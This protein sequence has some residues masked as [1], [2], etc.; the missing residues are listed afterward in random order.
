M[1]SIIPAAEQRCMRHSPWSTIG[2]DGIIVNLSRFKGVAVDVGNGVATVTGGTPMKELQGALHPHKRFAAVG[3]GNTVGVILYYLGGGISIYTPLIGFGAE[4]IVSARLVAAAGELVEAT[5]QATPSSSG[6]L[7]S[8][9]Q[10]LG[11]VTALMIRTHPYALTGGSACAALM[12]SSRTRPTPALHDRAGSPSLK[13]QVLLV[14]PHAD[15]VCAA[16]AAIAERTTHVSAGH[17]MIAQAP[18]LTFCTP[19]LFRPLLALGPVQHALRP[20]WTVDV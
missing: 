1:P 17:L 9:G 2:E 4:N 3:S 10:F 16:V 6:G 13:Q 7:R 12:S 18:S 19:A 5:E 14:A 11:L 20:P 15:A 8:V